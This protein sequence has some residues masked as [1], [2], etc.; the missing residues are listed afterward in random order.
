MSKNET[1]TVIG[2]EEEI[3]KWEPTQGEL[4][5][6]EKE[7]K[8]MSEQLEASPVDRFITVLVEWDA[9]ESQRLSAEERFNLRAELPGLDRNAVVK[10]YLTAKR[11][12]LKFEARLLE[13]LGMME[14]K[15]REAI[16]SGSR[17]YLLSRPDFSRLVTIKPQLSERLKGRLEQMEETPQETQAVPSDG[18][19]RPSPVTSPEPA[20]VS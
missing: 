12:V 11:V 10:E 20:R 19:Q 2:D 15:E 13:L 4:D 1:K 18:L 17:Q 3:E 7:L 8:A 5:E 9:W 16:L 6:A 14:D